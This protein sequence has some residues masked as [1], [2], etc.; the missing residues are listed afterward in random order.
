MR[1]M[2]VFPA[3][4][5]DHRLLAQANGETVLQTVLNTIAGV[6]QKMNTVALHSL[7]AIRNHF[8]I[9]NCD[10]AFHHGLQATR[11][12]GKWP[13]LLVLR[14]RMKQCIRTMQ[15]RPVREIWDETPGV[16]IHQLLVE[17]KRR[18]SSLGDDGADDGAL[19]Q[20]I[21]AAKLALPYR[22]VPSSS[23]ASRSFE[24]EEFVN[25]KIQE[26]TSLRAERRYE[27]ADRIARALQAMGIIIDDHKKTWMVGE[28]AAATQEVRQQLDEKKGET[29][30][31]CEMCGR[32]FA[33]RNL[34]FKHLRDPVSSSCGTSI[35][36]SNQT[37]AKAPSAIKKEERKKQRQEQISHR[38]RRKTGQTAV[39][40]QHSLWIGDLPLL[41]TRHGGNYKRLRALLRAHLPR[42]IAQPWIKLVKRKAYRSKQPQHN[43]SSEGNDDCA[44][45]R[46]VYLGYAI[47]IF[48]DAKETE[49]VLRELDGQE[50]SVSSVFSKQDLEVN[51]DSAR[52]A[53]EENVPL[54]R[55]KVR[56]VEYNNKSSTSQQQQQEKEEPAKAVA[57]EKDPPLVDQLKPLSTRELLTRT[58]QLL[59]GK[60]A[61]Q[62]EMSSDIRTNGDDN[63]A[64]ADDLNHTEALEQAVAA[65]QSRGD[66][67]SRRPEIRH[68]GRMI[69][70]D[71]CARLLS[72][73]QNLRWAV[74]NHRSGLTAECYLVL[75]TNVTN[76]LFYQDLRDACHALMDWADA[77]YFYS[78][79]AVTKNFVSSPHI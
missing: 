38:H 76:D 34:V 45:R 18:L 60:D 62:H 37:L 8:D 78:G 22:Q 11:A 44:D 69:P 40:T 17:V 13:L 26:R 25:Q 55:L 9:L 5:F 51:K 24:E 1:C 30:V 28:A 79:I 23:S 67:I 54:F 7:N 58:K 36:A 53:T 66:I 4:F 42:T 3:R 50:V 33:S 63:D 52:L 31:K 29:A 77:N 70:A 39:H 48:R 65:Y 20:Q 10:D 32:S 15:S 61:Q 49:T 68:K 27:E 35:F 71:I 41:W 56:P 14:G 75:Q 16:G 43:D 57:I 21:K 47:V 73:L 2:Y 74:P 12:E 6:T 46:G 59:V 19:K 72:I 64:S